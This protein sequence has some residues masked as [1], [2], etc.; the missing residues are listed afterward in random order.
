MFLTVV[1]LQ[2]LSLDDD[3]DDDADDLAD[4]VSGTE[5]AGDRLLA[6]KLRQATMLGRLT[7]YRRRIE[8]LDVV[9]CL[10]QY[11]IIFNKRGKNRSC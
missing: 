6:Y 2:K 4:G 5:P 7:D 3:D 9:V 11:Q 1:T 8:E 10:S